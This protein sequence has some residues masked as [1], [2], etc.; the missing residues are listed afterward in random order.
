MYLR[1]FGAFSFVFETFAGGAFLFPTLDFDAD[2]GFVAFGFGFGFGVPIVE[3]MV[4]F[5]VEFD[6]APLHDELRVRVCMS[7]KI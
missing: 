7:K 5:D 6:I 4:D 3:A 1:V 2:V